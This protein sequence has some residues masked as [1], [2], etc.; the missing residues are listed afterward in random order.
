MPSVTLR[1]WS[2]TKVSLLLLADEVPTSSIHK[3]TNGRDSIEITD[4]ILQKRR[5]FKNNVYFVGFA[6]E[7][8]AKIGD[9]R[10]KRLRNVTLNLFSLFLPIFNMVTGLMR[11]R[12]HRSLH[13]QHPGFFYR[14]LRCSVSF[15]VLNL[16]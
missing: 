10:V 14:H 7:I 5:S 3:N 1:A 9:R 4:R 15:H 11:I 6:S 12:I 2:P 13:Q 16:H 8:D